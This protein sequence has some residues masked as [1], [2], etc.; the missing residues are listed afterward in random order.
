MWIINGDVNEFIGYV[1]SLIITGYPVTFKITSGFVSFGGVRVCFGGMEVYFKQKFLG[2]ISLGRVMVPSSKIVINLPTNNEN[3]ISSAVSD[4]LW[5]K[6][7]TDRQTSCYFI[8]TIR[9]IIVIPR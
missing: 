3:H 2:A 9:M 1:L 5:Y 4:I 8:I 7:K 6:Q